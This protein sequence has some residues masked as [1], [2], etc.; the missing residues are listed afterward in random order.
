M[1][2]IN[3]SKLKKEYPGDSTWK[4]FQS[5]TVTKNPIFHNLS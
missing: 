5:K 3:K 1:R 4:G 2:Q